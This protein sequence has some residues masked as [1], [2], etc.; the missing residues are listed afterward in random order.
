MFTSQFDT[1]GKRSNGIL[2]NSIFWHRMAAYHNGLVTID[3]I[4]SVDSVYN[5]HTL[6]CSVYIGHGP[7]NWCIAILLFDQQIE[8]AV[9]QQIIKK[10]IKRAYHSL[11][12]LWTIKSFQKFVWFVLVYTVTASEP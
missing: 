4:V 3:C 8:L 9:D 5:V 12:A 11:V 7:A 10:L 1:F 6:Q 2:A